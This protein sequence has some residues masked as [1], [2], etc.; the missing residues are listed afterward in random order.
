MSLWT[1]AAIATLLPDIEEG[2]QD[3]AARAGEHVTALIERFTHLTLVRRP[4]PTI[5]RTAADDPIELP[6]HWRPNPVVTEVRGSDDKT[7]GRAGWPVLEYDFDGSRRVYSRGG[8]PLQSVEGQ[9]TAY[10]RRYGYARRDSDSRLLPSVSVS[11]SAGVLEAPLGGDLAVPEAAQGYADLLGVAEDVLRIV[12]AMREAGP[13]I[14]A[15]EI[16]SGENRLR[17]SRS[18]PKH[19]VDTLDRYSHTGIDGEEG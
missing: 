19:V 8:W 12:W 13:L 7:V 11:G 10:P 16:T 14:S 15:E 18:W 5:H 4:L 6:E 1:P 2:E 3:A 17:W 9:P